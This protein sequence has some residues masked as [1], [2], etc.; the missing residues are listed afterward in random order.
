[1]DAALSSL[2][3]LQVASYVDA[4][5]N[6]ATPAVDLVVS[7]GEKKEDRVAFRRAGAEVFVTRAGEPG[8]ARVEAAKF[9]EAL[10]AI[11]ALNK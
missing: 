6:A 9:D 1:M 11:D 2:S 3:G 5:P 10:A 8:A 4:L 7:F